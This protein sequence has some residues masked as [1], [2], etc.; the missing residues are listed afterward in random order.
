MT[1]HLNAL[2]IRRRLGRDE[3]M[4]PDEFGPD[5]WMIQ[6]KTEPMRIIVPEFGQW[7]SI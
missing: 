4:V 6:S 5:G 1:S 2:D 3:W 7:G